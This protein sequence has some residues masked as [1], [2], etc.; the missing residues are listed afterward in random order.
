M[1]KKLKQDSDSYIDYFY[2]GFSKLLNSHIIII[3]L[4]ESNRTLLLNN[5]KYDFKIIDSEPVFQKIKINF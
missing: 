4:Y 3:S 5:A 1:K 2:I